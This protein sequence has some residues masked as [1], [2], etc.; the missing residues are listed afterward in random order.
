MIEEFASA[1]GD[2]PQA[3]RDRAAA[4]FRLGVIRS[5]L[6]E[7]Q[8]SE[9]NF[10]VARDLFESLPQNELS[11]EDRSNQAKASAQLAVKFAETGRMKESEVEFRRAQSMW[12]ELS[13]DDPS[14]RVFLLKSQSNLGKL[15]YLNG[16]FPAAE[17]EYRDGIATAATIS[18]LHT[19][20]MARETLSDIHNGLGVVCLEQGKLP[21]SEEQYRLSMKIIA[22]LKLEYPENPEHAQGL[23]NSHG[24]LAK[25]LALTGR[26]E[27]AEAEQRKAKE[28]RQK[29]VA[30]FPSVP[31]YKAGLAT[32]QISFGFLLAR[33]GRSDEAVVEYRESRDMLR[34]LCA[35]LPKV[36]EYQRLLSMALGNIGNAFL[37]LE[38]ESEALDA[39]E[40]SLRVQR[41]LNE[42][43]GQTPES[44]DAYAMALNN[45]GSVY[46]STGKLNEATE[47][48]VAAKA[49]RE[50]LLTMLP[51]DSELHNGLAGILVN[52]AELKLNI[53]KLEEAKALL[54]QGRSHHDQ[55]LA[56]NVK[57]SIYIR[58]FR[59]HLLVLGKVLAQLAEMEP[60]ETNSA[61]LV[62]QGMVVEAAK[63]WM[64]V[65]AST[66]SPDAKSTRES[67]AISLLR[68]SLRA[69]S[70]S[71][72]QVVETKEFSSIL[73]KV[74]DPDPPQN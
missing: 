12:R 37:S 68:D 56:A 24:N 19:N 33:L 36:V 43:V 31:E 16:Q 45:L 71:K 62:A 46:A 64:T 11:A 72:E 69:G 18:D 49:I 55:A 57:N 4:I 5:T 8:R 7:N 39:M 27:E 73:A 67:K 15:H 44:E 60:L 48:L 1:E 66:D 53:G 40:E 42:L 22:D 30:D 29:L 32:N 41:A 51:N 35:K 23:A 9:E 65:A 17:L 59:N 54:K 25:I 20:E 70:I 14:Q 50:K 61:E 52:L 63:N 6:G 38:Q 21:E 28:I 10:I 26:N 34:S 2:E 58:F 74:F 47:M 13:K 3:I